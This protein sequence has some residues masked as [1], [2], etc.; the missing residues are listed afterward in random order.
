MS[1]KTTDV[2]TQFVD[3]VLT[4][5]WGRLWA[6]VEELPDNKVQV[7]FETVAAAGFDPKKVVPGKLVGHYRDQD[8]SRTGKTYHINKVCPYKVM[9]M[10]DQENGDHYFATGWLDCAVRRVLYG[11]TRQK[12][13]REQLIATL[14]AEIERSV[15]LVPIQLSPEGEMLREYPPA[16]LFAGLEYFVDHT[17]DSCSLNSCIGIHEYCDGWMDRTPATK[18]HDAI[19]C[20]VCRLRVLFP[21]KVKTFRELR[22]A[23]ASRV[24]VPLI[25]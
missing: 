12:E 25:V 5:D 21:K 11:G 1:S 6:E 16:P 19:L 2:A 15:P 8:G 14:E 18:T 13:N 4:S 24:Q 3:L 10:V 22:Q 20:R 9:G 23:L 7:F 17:R